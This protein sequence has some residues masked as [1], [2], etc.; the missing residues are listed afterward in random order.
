[1]PEEVKQKLEHLRDLTQA[2]S[3]SEVI[4]RALAVYD[5]LWGEKTNGSITLLRSRDGDEKELVLL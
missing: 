2:D 1:M 4:R 5:F 3:M